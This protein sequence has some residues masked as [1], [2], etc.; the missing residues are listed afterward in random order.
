MAAHGHPTA[1]SMFFSQLPQAI[2]LI[3]SFS[4][5]RAFCNFLDVQKGNA[6][7]EHVF[8]PCWGSVGKS[9]MNRIVFKHGY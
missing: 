4:I 8:N 5:E 1:R 7:F 2:F 6:S 9:P 3:T